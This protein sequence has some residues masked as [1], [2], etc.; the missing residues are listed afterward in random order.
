MRNIYD[1]ISEQKIM[2]D[3][4]INNYELHSINESFN[5]LK[6]TID[7]EYIEEG[8]SDIAD[9]VVQF[10]KNMLAKIRE[11]VGK[12]INFFKGKQANKGDILENATN[13]ANAKKTE[14]QKELTKEEIVRIVKTSQVKV[15]VIKYAALPVKQKMADE[16]LN[17]IYSVSE[18]F[19]SDKNEVN[20]QFRIT[21]IKKAFKGEGSYSKN[22]EIGIVDR[23]KLELNEPTEPQ[24]YKIADL[25]DAILSY[26]TNL[27]TVTGGINKLYKQVENS[28]N[29]LIKKVESI[30][31]DD[32]ASINEV[33]AMTTMAGQFTNYMC[34][35]IVTAFNQSES[36]V[37][38]A[39]DAHLG[40]KSTDDK[41]SND[42]T[43]N[44]TENKNNNA[45]NKQK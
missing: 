14:T 38:K 27:N 16:V 25:A 40:V 45:D 29:G 11:L 43:K 9:K 19:T 17:A 24:E 33:Q 28:L 10:I 7:Y 32:K 8:L 3:M 15:N 35:S 6:S 2:V 23:A 13:K 37:L 4:Q 20:K 21:I 22:K 5:T 18:L 34:T 44:N 41:S 12:V 26:A 39:V 42:K 31:A 30:S 36:L 1:I